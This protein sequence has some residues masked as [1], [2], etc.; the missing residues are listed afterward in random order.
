MLKHLRILTF[1]IIIIVILI[2]I[3]LGPGMRK[4]LETNG[5][6]IINEVK[7]RSDDHILIDRISGDFWSGVLIERLI[8]YADHDPEHLPLLEADMVTLKI[9]IG[10][11]L[12]REWE[13]SSI[14][15]N[16]FNAVL[17]I[18]TEGKL[19]LPDWTFRTARTDSTQPLTAGLSSIGKNSGIQISCENGVLEI[20]KRFP[21]LT[22]TVNV[23]FTQLEG[24]GEYIDGEGVTVESM[25]GDYLSTPLSF[26]GLIPIDENEDMRFQVILGE[27]GLSTVFRDIDPLFRGSSYFPTGTASL[28]LLLSGTR[29]YPVVTGALNLV[30]TTAGNIVL[31]AAH[32]DIAYSAGVID[33]TDMTADTYGGT[34]NGS[35]LI[36]LLSTEPLWQADCSFENIDLAE[37]L[38]SNGYYAYEVDGGFSG[39][40]DVRGDFSSPDSLEIDAVITS[41]GG[42]FLSP[43]SDRFMNPAMYALERSEPS[44]A[45][46]TTYSS[47]SIEAL[48][49]DSVIRIDRFQ[50]QSHELQVEAHGYIGFDHSISASGGLTIPLDKARDHPKLGGVVGFLPDT[51]QRVAL[52]FSL[53]GW[54]HDMEFNPQIGENFL[55]GILDRTDDAYH[56]L[57]DSVTGIGN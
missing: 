39:S 19:A 10:A 52:E 43:F 37:Y 28:E 6:S 5:S 1:G 55:R 4:F 46:M 56:D 27:I 40:A 24:R 36:N 16:G 30:N 11:I 14:H 44:E 25:T 48:I 49:Q 53:S 7:Q 45:D 29:D 23:H 47:A 31:T 35:G 51:L 32:A 13:A 18:D 21:N 33:L 20:F 34:M 42:R 8:I 26:S 50:L 41:S 38:D 2:W 17:H 15:I 54:L 9:P 12:R 57:A 3:A 22:E